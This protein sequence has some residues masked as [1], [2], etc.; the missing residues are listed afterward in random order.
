[1]EIT[2]ATSFLASLLLINCSIAFCLLHYVPV[3]NNRFQRNSLRYFRAYFLC[4]VVGYIGY[5]IRPVV[6]FEVSVA[7]TNLFML[8]SVYCVVFALYWRFKQEI[9][10]NTPAVAFHLIV[11][12]AAQT[13]LSILYP[14][15]YLLRLVL[16]YINVT[17][18]LLYALSLFSRFRQKS[19]QTDRLLN[20]ALLVGAFNVLCVPISYLA[21]SSSMMFLNIMLASQNIVVFLMFGAVLYTLFYDNYLILK[22]S[23]SIDPVSGVYN[24]RYF[25]EQANKFL[26]AAQRHQFPLSIILCDIDNF[27]TI[28]NRYGQGAADQIA[29]QIAKVLK[30][31][32]RQEDFIARF[33]SEAFVL[34]LPQTRINGAQLIAERIELEIAKLKF[35]FS[36]NSVQLIAKTGVTSI[37]GYTDIQT[38][39][40]DVQ[41][42]M[43]ASRKAKADA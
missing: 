5:I 40:H 25:I 37:S 13:V 43:L 23:A 12:T 35:D 16:V 36:D 17:A 6:L 3:E 21:T 41:E 42:Q 1:M 4:I 15:Y 30:V 22:S 32:M 24:Q 8:T 31:E 19:L 38:S 20:I 9:H 10:F 7:I 34:L 27:L 11:F 14:D 18:V 26:S 2:T 39:I 28:K 29:K 33:S